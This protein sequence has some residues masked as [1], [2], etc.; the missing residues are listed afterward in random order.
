MRINKLKGENAI[1]LIALIVTIIVLLILAMVSVSLVLRENLIKKAKTAKNEYELAAQD[2]SDQLNELENAITNSLKN[3]TSK[4]P[5]LIQKMFY[6]DESVTLSF[7]E[8]V[9][10]FDNYLEGGSGLKTEYGQILNE[11][12]NIN[13]QKYIFYIWL[14]TLRVGICDGKSNLETYG[15]TYQLDEEKNLYYVSWNAENES[16]KEYKF[17]VI[18]NGYTLTTNP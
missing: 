2:E 4:G 3:P 8:E 1:T 6:G 13:G 12:G 17:Y 11:S 7:D 18:D 14:N 15:V 10:L 5:E 16:G 9:E